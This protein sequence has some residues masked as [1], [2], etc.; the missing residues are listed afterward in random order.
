MAVLGLNHGEFNSSAAIVVDG[1]V[2]AGAPEERF[3]RQKRTK[4]FPKNASRY[5]LESVNV[6]LGDLD[7]VGQGW[8]PAAYWNAYNPILSSNRLSR[9]DYFYTVP[10]NLLTIGT[11]QS[12]QWVAMS[13]PAGSPLPPTYF[14]DHH[15][16]HA[17]TA[18]FTSPFEDA[19]VFTADFRGEINCGMFGLGQDNTLTSLL[20]LSLPNSLGMIYATF[21]QLLG[22]TPDSDE[23]KVMALSSFP[24]DAS[25]EKTA[26]RSTIQ[27]TDDGW[28]E[29]DQ[30]YYRGLLSGQPTLYTRKLVDLLGGR[31]GIQAEEPGEWHFRVAKAMQEVAEEIAVHALRRLHEL[32]G[33][34][35]VALGGGFFMNS[36]LNGRI[37]NLTPFEEVFVPFAPADV[38]NSIGSAL[39]VEHVILGRDRHPARSV[40]AI[41][42]AFTDG[43]VISALQRR[44]I[45]YDQMT[46]RASDL[47]SLILEH[48]M[49]AVLDGP[50]EFGERALGNRSIL[51]DPRQATIKDRINATIKYREAYRPFAPAA[52]L[53]SAHLYFDLNPGEEVP[54]MEKVVTVRSEYREKLAA[55]THVDGSGRLQTVRRQDS[56]H[57]HDLL[58][59]F[60][61]LS[62]FPILLNT[63]FNVNGE[64]IVCT[65]DDALSTFFNSGLRVLVMGDIVVKK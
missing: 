15:L 20:N 27:F 28:F 48:G 25:K 57:F 52:P 34:R 43:E 63:S 40:S 33:L 2:V 45:P 41:G 22:Y 23:W 19:A 17:S 32:T 56:P 49:V 30:S 5:C 26:I 62:G 31:E 8:N 58:V 39:F 47:A 64:P 4:R 1:R 37:T 36:V 55:I 14:V 42:P 60:E 13:Y 35:R 38:G 10:D 6:E 21:T 9:E 18:F 59:A 50:M 29:L 11:R 24:V 65:P 44:G 7:A 53:E 61:R 12:P 3:S 46:N 51:A 16:C 54:F